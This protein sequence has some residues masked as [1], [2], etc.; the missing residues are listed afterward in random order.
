M[1]PLLLVPLLLT[2]GSVFLAGCGRRESP[3][4][5]ALKTKVLHV[6]NFAEPR[7]L[8]P[9]VVTLATDFNPIFALF[10]GLLAFDEATA[11]PIPCIAERWEISADGLTCTFH[12]RADARWSNGDPVTAQDF[13]YSFRRV[14][15][16]A[17]GAEYAYFLWPLKNAE[18]FTTGKLKDFAQVGIAVPDART[19]RLTLE[20][21]HPFLL[22]LAAHP[23]W[24]PVHRATIEKFGRI[25]QR[26]TAWTR[27]GNLVS[28]GAFMLSEWR[29]QSHVTVAKNPHYRDAA[30]NRLNAVVFRPIENSE[31]EERNFRAGQL[32]ITDR[33]PSSKIPTY[34]AQADSA[35]R[36]ENMLRSFYIEMNVTRPPL[37]R[38]EIRRALGL[39]IDR[40]A[41]TRNVGQGVWL[42][43]T[44][45]VPPGCI[46]YTP[47]DAPV[48]NLAEARRLLAAAGHPLGQGL[49]PLTIVITHD[50]ERG[51]VAQI[52]QERWQKELGVVCTIEKNEQ[53]VWNE[54][55][56]SHRYMISISGWLA[57]YPDASAFL[58]TLR[59]GNGN[60]HCAWSDRGF[61]ELMRRSDVTSGAERIALLRQAEER[62]LAAAPILP[63]YYAPK[64]RL[65]HPSVRGW[66]ASPLDLHRYHLLDLQ[67]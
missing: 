30:R 52:I 45:F 55:V 2:L 44:S 51:M 53:K 23:S 29:P 42:P 41:I 50:V 62:M 58:D 18:A 31:S 14:L 25:D 46:D 37:D 27:P 39:A 7:D 34:R 57:D 54:A 49:P 40:G 15:S 65:V 66:T 22:S 13:A 60:N 33:F 8:D 3:V 61:D 4:Q 64:A 28:N 1:R 47:P 11:Q 59:T 19:L 48:E 56:I 21:P 9:H 35:L 63:L 6:G 17:F 38:V 67:P 20:R 26:G 36:I 12:L 24:F 5:A 32:H 43:A 16:P 10:E